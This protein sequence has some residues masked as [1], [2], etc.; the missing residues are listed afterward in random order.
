MN[1]PSTLTVA[2]SRHTSPPSPLKIKASRPLIRFKRK[3]LSH[4]LYLRSSRNLVNQL[5]SYLTMLFRLDQT[6]WRFRPCN[7]LIFQSVSSWHYKRRVVQ[8]FNCLLRA[9]ICNVAKPFITCGTTLFISFQVHYYYLS[10]CSLSFVCGAKS[11]MPMWLISTELLLLNFHLL[12]SPI[13][14]KHIKS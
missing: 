6:H 5:M 10:F 1:S 14:L 11:L 13:S 8:P 9:Y 7:V 3:E 4:L 12:N 2:G